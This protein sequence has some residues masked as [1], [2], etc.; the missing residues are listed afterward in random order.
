[1]FCLLIHAWLNVPRSLLKKKRILLLFIPIFCL[2]YLI[3]FTKSKNSCSGWHWLLT[4]FYPTIYLYILIRDIK[5]SE[6][7]FLNYYSFMFTLTLG[8]LYCLRIS[9]VL[10]WYP[11]FSNNFPEG[12]KTI[13]ILSYLR[14]CNFIW[15]GWNILIFAEKFWKNPD[16]FCEFTYQKKIY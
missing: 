9:T 12:S 11:Q 1:M 13:C 4:C 14:M 7:S 10:G 3:F 2:Y 15:C 8:L 6:L 5:H 16:F